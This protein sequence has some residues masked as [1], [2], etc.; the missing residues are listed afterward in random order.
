[1]DL[2]A[3]A[4]AR[5]LGG[6]PLE[7]YTMPSIGR[8]GDLSGNLPP[9]QQAHHL[10]Q[11]AAYST[12]TAGARVIPPD[13]GIAVAMDGDAFAAAQR[14]SPH[15]LFHDSLNQFWREA[16]AIFT[17][18]NKTIM[19]TNE[20]YSQALVQALRAS[21]QFKGPNSENIIAVLVSLARQQRLSYGL[22][23]N[24]PIPRIPSR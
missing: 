10:N 22:L 13:D 12:N 11:N 20:Q 14:N 2:V 15:R 5:G 17:S 1:M 19:P 6:R 3:Q 4:A 8:Y 18:S 24:A 9:G 23:D 16:R 7:A 21:G